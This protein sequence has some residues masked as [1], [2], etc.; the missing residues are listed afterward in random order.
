MEAV[1][2]STDETRWLPL[3]FIVTFLFTGAIAYSIAHGHENDD[4]YASF[5]RSL[6]QPMNGASCCNDTDCKQT[7]YRIV[8]DHYDVWIEETQKWLTVPDEK[9]L[10]KIANPTGYA[11][12]C[13]TQYL[14]ILCFVSSAGM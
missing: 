7:D 5:Y 13:W 11:V 2:K 1:M 3:V 10:K 9:I 14:G 8:G 12:V 6:K 4:P